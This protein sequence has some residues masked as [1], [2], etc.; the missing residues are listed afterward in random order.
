[1]QTPL[2]LSGRLAIKRSESEVNISEL[3]HRIGTRFTGGI[4]RLIHISKSQS[5]TGKML[6]PSKKRFSEKEL[7][8][9]VGLMTADELKG[10]CAAV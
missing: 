4:Y 2:A 9:S 1:V 10:G 3:T 8:A 5:K 6:K 7:S